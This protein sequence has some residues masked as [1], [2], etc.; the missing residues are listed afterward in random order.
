MKVS[1]RMREFTIRAVATIGLMLMFAFP[2]WGDTVDLG[3][4]VCEQDGELGVFNGTTADAE[5]CVTPAEYAVMF[6]PDGLL[7]SGVI[8]GYETVGEEAVLDFG[9]GTTA[10]VKVKALDRKLAAGPDPE[11]EAPTVQEWFDSRVAGPR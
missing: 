9:D 5:G 11:P 3:N 10:S 4:G 7:E 8:V 1:P 6:S 2:A